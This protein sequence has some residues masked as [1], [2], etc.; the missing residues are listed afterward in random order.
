MLAATE[1]CGDGVAGRRR[2]LELAR[3]VVEGMLA[4]ARLEE[5]RGRSGWVFT[6]GDVFLASIS[7]DAAM[8]CAN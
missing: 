8:G 7:A 2:T 1:D 6:R 4:H 5:V 3:E